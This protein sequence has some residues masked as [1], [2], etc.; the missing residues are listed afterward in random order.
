M[1]CRIFLLALVIYGSI[2]IGPFRKMIPC[3]KSHIGF[4]K[5]IRVD[6]EKIFQPDF[7]MDNMNK[8][9]KKQLKKMPKIVIIPPPSEKEDWESGE[10]AWEPKP[11]EGEGEGEYEPK[12]K[13][14]E[15][16]NEDDCEDDNC[17]LDDIPK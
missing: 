4:K 8:Q 3:N 7:V 6:P 9:I 15:G 17:T 14:G 10:V 12:P 16:Q 11:K 2:G 5:E 1:F 13:E